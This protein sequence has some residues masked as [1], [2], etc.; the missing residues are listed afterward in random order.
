MKVAQKEQM[1]V[2]DHFV[3]ERR[4]AYQKTKQ[5]HK[6]LDEMKPHSTFQSLTKRDPFPGQQ[7]SDSHMAP[8][9]G[10]LFVQ[11]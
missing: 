10:G 5:L 6:Q 8:K 2:V 11:P 3:S 4:L 9:S 1:T 7:S